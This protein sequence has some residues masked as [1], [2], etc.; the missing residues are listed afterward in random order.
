MIGV[1]RAE[2][3]G[4]FAAVFSACDAESA[5]IDCGGRRLRLIRADGG[6]VHMLQVDIS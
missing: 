2:V 3:D 1:R 6:V 4:H 5:A